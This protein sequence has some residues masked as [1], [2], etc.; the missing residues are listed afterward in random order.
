MHTREVEVLV[1]GSGF[2]AAA[3]ALRMASAGFQ[4]LIIE[5]GADIVPERDFHQT[6]DP[7]YLLKYIKT[8]RGDNVNFTYAEGLGGGSGFYE[9]AS[10][11]APSKAFEQRDPRGIRLW[12]SGLSRGVMNP[13]FAT[14][15]RMMHVTQIAANR[16]PKTGLAFSLLMKRLGYS[17]DRAPYSVRNCAGHSFC[18]AGCTRGSK[19]T[20][21]D[22]Y[23]LPARWAGAE[24]LT[25][26]E[27]LTIYALPHQDGHADHTWSI[28]DIPFRYE[29]LCRDV[30]KGE[31]LRI[32]TKILILG[33]GTVGTAK[34]LLGSRRQLPLLSCQVG[35]NIAV[36]GTVKS[37]G[38]LPEGLIEG[39]MF[40]G[41]SHPGVI[42]YE[43]LE[44]KG[45]TISTA[46]PLPVDA[47][48]YANLVLD[49]ESRPHPWWGAPKVELMKLYRRRALVIFALGLTTPTA[50]VHL[51]GNGELE[52]RF[53]L[54]DVFRAY[55]HS[56]LNL[57][58]SIFR[59]NGARVVNI[60][61]I[62]GQGN[63]YPDLHITTAHMTG[64][65]R[66]ADSPVQ[67]VVDS[68]GEVFNY[69]GMYITDGA[70]VP[71][72]LAVNPYLTILANAERTADLLVH[73]YVGHRIRAMKLQ[74]RSRQEKE[75]IA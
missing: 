15:E 9:M 69:P 4:V 73:R 13:Y 1:V 17:V 53:H 52:S 66:M 40:V 46:K 72:S 74:S 67:G 27:A 39:D 25:N 6:Q 59:R 42:S 18:V 56:T 33:G 38:I 43:F 29:V 8:I 58:H 24:I 54:D 49:G 51:R 10:F 71:S 50:E 57:L 16:I 64:S 19:V 48:S 63:E 60:R 28:N 11:R 70:S 22:T 5:K 41:Q 26:M 14:A 20:L 36:N 44:K 7:K 21:H 34:L 37:L 30:L 62:D 61:I 47:V 68:S 32:R 55:Y 45:I 65:C 75:N 2:G 3:P 35:R 23:L 31:T 12:P